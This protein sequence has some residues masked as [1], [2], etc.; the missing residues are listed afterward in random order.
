MKNFLF[1]CLL[2]VSTCLTE[3]VNATENS[4]RFGKYQG[5]PFPF[6][7]PHPGTPGGGGSTDVDRTFYQSMSGAAAKQVA[8]SMLLK[9]MAAFEQNRTTPDF[10]VYSKMY[11]HLRS[12]VLKNGN[13]SYCAQ[14]DD[15]GQGPTAY[16]EPGTYS[17]YICEWHHVNAYI[18][19]HEA[20]HLAGILNECNADAWTKSVGKI[21]GVRRLVGGYDPECLR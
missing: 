4:E 15:E 7:P 18:L 9:A 6:R 1:I 19:L 2:I 5:G 12:A 14:K 10:K 11:K 17:I 3:G 21:V 16:A 8:E 20:A 13:P